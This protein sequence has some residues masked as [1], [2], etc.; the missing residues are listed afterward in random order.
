MA[1]VASTLPLADAH[2][3]DNLMQAVGQTPIRKMAS[4]GVAEENRQALAAM[5]EEAQSLPV[6]DSRLQPRPLSG[7]TGT[8][9]FGGR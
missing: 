9:E 1:E 3:L 8:Q 5:Y 4:T 6:A 7:L 2:A